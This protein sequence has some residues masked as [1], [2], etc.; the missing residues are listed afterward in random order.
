MSADITRPGG[1]RPS[2]K[3]G[4]TSRFCLNLAA[5][6]SVRSLALVVAFLIAC[7]TS[8]TAANFTVPPTPDHYVV[9]TGH[10]L[11][12][13][14]TAALETELRAFEKATGHQIVV[15]IALTTGDVPLETYTAETAHTWRIGRKGKDDGAILFLFMKDHKVRIEV[16]YGLEGSLTDATANDI[17]QSEIVPRMRQDDT[18]GAVTAGVAKMLAA[19]DPSFTPTATADPSSTDDSQGSV[20][21]PGLGVVIFLILFCIPWIWVIWRI[22]YAARNGQLITGKGSSSGGGGLFGSSSSSDDFG[23][24]DDFDAGGGDFGGG[25]ASGSW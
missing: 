3:H 4:G 1:R 20:S 13:D 18:D 19:I 6:L 16:G 17:I 12:D 15:Y 22:I 24:S 7:A 10:A 2:R 5:M 21:S 25:G 23:G 14:T 11:D 8:A 9:D